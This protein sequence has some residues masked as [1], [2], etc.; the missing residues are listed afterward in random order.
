MAGFTASLGHYNPA[1]AW[2]CIP[3][4]LRFLAKPHVDFRLTGSTRIQEAEMVLYHHLLA[5]LLLMAPPLLVQ[6]SSPRP[7]KGLSV[8]QFD[9]PLAT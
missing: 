7:V 3:Q 5:G 2:G 8:A 6:V 4:L 1:L 9:R